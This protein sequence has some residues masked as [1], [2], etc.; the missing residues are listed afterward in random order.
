MDRRS[1]IKG[2]VAGGCVVAGGF[3]GIKAV[4]G[5][6]KPLFEPLTPMT[7]RKKP[8]EEMEV[9]LLGTGIPMASVA[10][11]KP[12]QVVLAGDRAFVVDCG[13]GVV[14][15]MLQAGVVPESIDN[16]FITHHHSDHNSGFT[17][18]LISGLV[19][20]PL[21]GRDKPMNVFGP[22]NTAEVIG[23]LHDHLQ[24]DI[25]LRVTQT[26]DDP[27]GARLV[28]HE[29]D[30]GLVYDDEGLK[31]TAFL[32]D[33]GMVKPAVGYKFEYKG[34]T[35]VISGDTRPCEAVI[36]HAEKADILIHE[37]YSQPWIEMGLQR[38][39]EKAAKAEAV[40]K[41][42]SSTLEAAEIARKAGV[43]H[44]VFTHLMP[45][46]SPVWYF[47]RSWAGGVSDIYD[48]KIT[49]GRDLMSFS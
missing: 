41:Y 48:G 47:E 3:A 27:E 33:H 12:A 6:F 20:G 15:R 4:A 14:G 25:Y 7:L 38:F 46:P 40:K 16:V 34:R 13:S 24:W 22:T 31:I 30:E 44:L 42:H 5:D 19:G 45:S 10:R 49:V 17:D 9:V 37:A 23:K 39:P 21:P 1:F 11:S 8:Y 2:A 35:I 18:L 43:K 28:Y 32:V 36:K 26:L 29:S